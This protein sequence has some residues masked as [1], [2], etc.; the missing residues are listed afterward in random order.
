MNN[1]AQNIR[2]KKKTALKTRLKKKK[3]NIS[4]TPLKSKSAGIFSACCPF[5][6]DTLN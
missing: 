1:E 5:H 6:A 3:K 4:R 2:K